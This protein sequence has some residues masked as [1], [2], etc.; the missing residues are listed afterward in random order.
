MEIIEKYYGLFQELFRKIFLINSFRKILKIILENFRK[1][2]EIFLEISK[3]F[4]E[5]FEKI[6]FN[7]GKFRELLQRILR[8]I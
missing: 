8:F 4:N 3:N 5:I 6:F 2:A 1:I 7:F